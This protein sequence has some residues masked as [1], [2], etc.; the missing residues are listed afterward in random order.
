MIAA[1]GHNLDVVGARAAMLFAELGGRDV[2]LVYHVANGPLMA[3]A[4][5]AIADAAAV[6]GISHR[7]V[8]LPETSDATMRL[9]AAFDATRGAGILV[10]G[11]DVLP[12]APGWLAPWLCRLVSAR[13]ILGGTLIDAAGAVLHAGAVRGDGPL[14][15]VGL[16]SADL[17]DAPAASTMLVSTECVGLTRSAAELVRD[18]G[19]RYPNPNVMLAETVARLRAEGREVATLLRCRFVRYTDVPVDCF[20][21]AVDFGG[22][23]AGP[24]A[25]LQ[26]FQR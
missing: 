7:L 12:A 14:R 23:A 9:L 11:A 22:V 25:F 10:L 1:V 20:G 18:S 15:H 13:P 2:E 16:P 8:V 4:R 21:E 26:P 6:F 17:P 24:K 19:V 3:A 5:A